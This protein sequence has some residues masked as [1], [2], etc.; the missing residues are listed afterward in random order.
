MILLW[1]ILVLLKAQI[2]MSHILRVKN[3]ARDRKA[4]LGLTGSV[5][6]II[7]IKWE[8]ERRC[9][10]KQGACRP[11]V[12]LLPECPLATP[13]VPSAGGSLLLLPHQQIPALLSAAGLGS[14]VLPQGPVII[15]TGLGLP[16]QAGAPA[17]CFKV[18]LSCYTQHPKDKGRSAWFM[19]LSCRNVAF[20]KDL[21]EGA[22]SHVSSLP[23]YLP[24]CS[25]CPWIPTVH[26]VALTVTDPITYVNS[27]G[28]P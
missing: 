22:N 24:F 23:T 18:R 2:F 16:A 27:S 14:A 10:G 15:H 21:R 3:V 7:R 25:S 13:H 19:L 11:G 9:R 20:G 8:Y 28:K 6:E 26:R 17:A 4:S 1:A 5:V 12:C